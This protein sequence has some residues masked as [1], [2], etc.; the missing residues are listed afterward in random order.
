MTQSLLI[1]IGV[2][3][4]P[5]I[6]LLKIVSN[7]EKSWQ[8]ILSD[9]QLSCEFEFIYT[10]RRL[11]LRHNAIASCQDDSIIELVGPPVMASIKD[12]VVTKAGEGFA[13]K[14][15][16][17]FESLGRSEK[18][19]RE[20]LYFQQKQSGAETTDLL[21]EMI[22][23]WINSMSFGKMMRWGD[24]S[25]EFIRPLRW[26][27]V[28]LDDSSVPVEIFGVK[29]DIYT[30]VHRMVSYESVEV[31]KVEDYDKILSDG[32]VMLYPKDRKESILR[33]FDELESE[34]G[35]IIERDLDLLAEVVAITENPKALGGSFDEVFLELPP[36]VIITSMKEHQRYFPVF[37]NGKISNK[38]V[39]AHFKFLSKPFVGFSIS[40]IMLH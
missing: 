40:N 23:K 29:S 8:K 37:E 17:D 32:A 15:G 34:Y 36:E 9:Y 20:V 33:D 30:F 28:R 27:Q 12:G 22:L 7:I 4:L 2:E 16:V 3:E 25:D 18:N 5:A 39:C 26:L 35:I 1:E 13:R 11:V 31:A 19:G 38:F 6:P 24:R 10:P 14:C 21:Q